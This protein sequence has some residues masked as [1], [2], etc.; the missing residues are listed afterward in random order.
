ME[1]ITLDDLKRYP[2]L[3]GYLLEPFRS[4]HQW[5][6][7]ILFVY[8]SQCYY[9]FNHRLNCNG[10]DENDLEKLVLADIDHRSNAYRYNRADLTNFTLYEPND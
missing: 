2:N 6:F 8:C 7:R 10:C 9:E 3:K 4:Y 5:D 1:H